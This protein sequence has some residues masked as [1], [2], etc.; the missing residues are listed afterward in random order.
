MDLLHEAYNFIVMYREWSYAQ[1]VDTRPLFSPPIWPG[2]EAKVTTYL[3]QLLLCW[4]KVQESKFKGFSGL[5]N[6]TSQKT[7]GNTI[8][9]PQSPRAS[10]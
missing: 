7:M 9:H 6:S 1:A 2:N 8:T 4:A 3:Y 10:F 5:S